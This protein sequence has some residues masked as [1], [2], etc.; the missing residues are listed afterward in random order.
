MTDRKFIASQITRVLISDLLI[1]WHAFCIARMKAS[2]QVLRIICVL[3]T[4]PRNPVSL[5]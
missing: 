5:C 3:I 4:Q 1:C 2:S